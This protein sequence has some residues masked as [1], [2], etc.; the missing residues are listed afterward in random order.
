MA[1]LAGID[2]AGYGPILGPLVVS[3]SAF[4]IPEPLLKAD[5]WQHLRKSSAVKKKHLAGRLL[6]TDSKKAYSRAA[7]IRH[8]Q[9]TTLA[10]LRCLGTEPT[11][12]NS[13]LTFLCPACPQR[14]KT[15]PWYSNGESVTLDYDRADVKI[16]SDVFSADM[17]QHGIRLLNVQSH[18]LDV[19]HY[20]KLIAAVKNKASVLFSATAALIKSIWDNYPDENIQIIVD[21]QGGRSRYR[22]NLQ[23]MFSD[24]DL[25]VIN[26]SQNSSSYE[27]K[28]SERKM[29]IHFVIKADQ[30][31]MPVCLASMVSKYVRE[32]LIAR[33]N[34]YFLS[35]HEQLKPTAGYFKD[36]RRFIA[37]IKTYI[38]NIKYDSNLLIRCR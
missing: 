29:R 26:E 17:A 8:I 37:D 24:L 13:L 25:V 23:R 31:Y 11:D 16:A 33:I 15:Y 9:R 18:C 3:A 22:K 34:S 2:E 38:P 1:V 21:R 30:R 10:V 32:L 5:L 12:L 27:L 6:I 14:L 7:G 20:N 35:H 4:S 36:G 19:A 28:D